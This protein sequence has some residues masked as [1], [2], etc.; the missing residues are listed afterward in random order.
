MITCPNCSHSNPDGAPFCGGCGTNLSTPPAT[1]SSGA[2]QAPALPLPVSAPLPP[3]QF[4]GRCG[5][6]LRA[7]GTC[8]RCLSVSHRPSRERTPLPPAPPAEPKPPAIPPKVL[9]LAAAGLIV[10]ALG[11]YGIKVLWGESVVVQTN[12]PGATVSVDGVEKA[13]APAAPDAPITVGHLHGKLHTIAVHVEGYLDAS[14][15]IVM[16]LRNSGAPLMFFL[17]PKP[18]T[19]HVQAIANSQVF[20]NNSFVGRTDNGGLWISPELMADRYVL[21]LRRPGYTDTTQELT[22]KP[23]ESR[24][25]QIAQTEAPLTPEQIA[26]QIDE[27]LASANQKFLQGQYD[28]AKADC[29]AVLKKQ[30][31]NQTAKHLE[32][33][34]DVVQRTLGAK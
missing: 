33:Q 2:A 19:L 29:D 16:P 13:K 7:D 9:G 10:L 18:A 11:V 28:A 20:L 1:G 22:L 24:T 14:R 15:E 12:I 32:D 23:G 4:C 27:L 8:L 17:Q 34:I 26:A 25:L 31:D 6:E 21:A 5:S 3:R 30:A